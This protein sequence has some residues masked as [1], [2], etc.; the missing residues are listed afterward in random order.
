MVGGM[1]E[2]NRYW[3][4]RKILIFILL[5]SLDNDQ[6]YKI[7][8]L[9]KIVKRLKTMFPG[10]TCPPNP[11]GKSCG[12]YNFPILYKKERISYRERINLSF[13]LRGLE[14]SIEILGMS[15]LHNYAI[16]PLYFKTKE[17]NVLMTVFIRTTVL[18]VTLL[19]RLNMIE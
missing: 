6:N 8:N 3:K 11:Q 19:N 15:N 16:V 5:H 14:I 7:F 17:R 12:Q 2:Q 10:Q 13:F 18:C 4:D 9:F 1:M